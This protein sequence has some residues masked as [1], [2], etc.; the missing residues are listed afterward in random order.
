MSIYEI[1]RIDDDL[2]G[3]ELKDGKLPGR[4]ILKYFYNGKADGKYIGEFKDGKREGKGTRS[5]YDGTIYVGEWKYDKFHVRG[6]LTYLGNILDGYW[7]KGACES[8]I[9]DELNVEN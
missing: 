5:L 4:G 3:G 2:Y 7:H 9:G 1:I 6:T 8:E